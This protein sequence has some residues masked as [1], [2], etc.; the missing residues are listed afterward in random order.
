[1]F[2]FANTIPFTNR[3]DRYSKSFTTVEPTAFNV[4]EYWFNKDQNRIRDIRPDTLAQMLNLANIRPGGRYI[5]AD[6]ASGLVVAG[7]LERMG[8]PHI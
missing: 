4:C 1:M 3:N 8:G 6:D 7:I 5:V 2:I